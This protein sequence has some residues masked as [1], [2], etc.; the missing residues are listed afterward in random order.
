[1]TRD[2]FCLVALAAIVLVVLY[3]AAIEK[4]RETAAKL[5]DI[6]TTYA[7]VIAGCASGKGF[8]IESTHVRCKPRE[9]EE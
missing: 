3:E 6:A 9:V 4:E 8:Q 2:A 5:L 1:M 7:G